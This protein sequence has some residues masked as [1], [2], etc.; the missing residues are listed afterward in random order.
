[1]AD[2][3]QRARLFACRLGIPQLYS[4]KDHV[5][6]ADLCRIVS[7][8]D[9]LEVKVAER[10]LDLEPIPANSVAMGTARNERHVVPGRRHAP[11]ENTLR[12][13]PRP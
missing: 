1:V 12:P 10:A 4:E 9:V 7:H 3:Q 8:V 11:A 6:R 13:P 2:F 5:D